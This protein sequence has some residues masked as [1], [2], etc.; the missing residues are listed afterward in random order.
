MQIPLR[1]RGFDGVLSRPSARRV[2]EDGFAETDVLRRDFDELVFLD[3]FQGLLKAQNA[4]RR[5]PDRL[6]GRRGPHVRDVL[7]LAWVDVDVQFA[8]VLADNHAFINHLAWRDEHRAAILQRIDAVARRLALLESDQGAMLAAFH[9]AFVRRV[10][11]ENV[12]HDA[13][14]LRAGQKLRTEA[15]EAARRNDEFHAHIAVAL[16]HVGKLRL[17]LAQKL[18]DRAHVFLRHFDGQ[19]FHRLALLPVDGFVDNF[20]LAD[21]QLI[22]FAAHGLDQDGKM[23]LASARDLEGVRRVRFLDAERDVRFNFFEKPVADVARGHELTFA[24]REGAGVD[25]EGHGERRLVYL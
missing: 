21:L 12:A 19:V 7:L 22:A 16:V 14:A 17:A 1:P 9:V 24:A 18:H 25:A 6:V 20:R 13:V 4:R 8:G 3:V 23:Q 5:Q 15:D 2:I 10:A 11:M